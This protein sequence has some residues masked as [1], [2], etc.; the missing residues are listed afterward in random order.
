MRCFSSHR[1]GAGHGGWGFAQWAGWWPAA[2]QGAGA[3]HSQLK[4][5][6]SWKAFGE[7]WGKLFVE[8]RVTPF[9]LHLA[10]KEGRC[11]LRDTFLYSEIQS[12]SNHP[13][14]PQLTKVGAISGGL[15]P[16]NNPRSCSFFLADWPPIS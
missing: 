3:Q 9:P 13:V 7:P 6:A 14:S 5:R 15:G 11:P 8:H 16:G 4:K 2:W 1:G 12:N 10:K